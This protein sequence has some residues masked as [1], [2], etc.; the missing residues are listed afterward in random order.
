MQ[1]QNVGTFGPPTLPGCSDG[2]DGVVVGGR[3]RC[4]DGGQK[5]SHTVLCETLGHGVHLCFGDGVGSEIYPKSTVQL[6]IH[7][8]SADDGATPIHHDIGVVGVGMVVD[9]LPEAGSWVNDG[10]DNPLARSGS[11]FQWR[12]FCS[13]GVLHPQFTSDELFGRGDEQNV[14]YFDDER[15]ADGMGAMG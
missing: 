5:G 10:T 12:V 2:G 13:D 7:K 11:C 9:S 15:V 1:T 4:N 14:H 6:K 8:T 3:R